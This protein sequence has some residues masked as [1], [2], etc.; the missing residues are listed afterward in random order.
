MAEARV[1]RFTKEQE[2]LR[3]AVT[4]RDALQRHKQAAAK[5]SAAAHAEKAA[6]LR[7]WDAESYGDEIRSRMLT[8]SSTIFSPGSTSGSVRV[9]GDWATPWQRCH[10]G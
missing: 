1:A 6:V 5:A 10:I 4:E 7:Q 3:R 2:G 8:S 9:A